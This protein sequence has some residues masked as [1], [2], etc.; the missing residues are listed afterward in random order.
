MDSWHRQVPALGRGSAA[1]RRFHCLGADQPMSLKGPSP[2][3]DLG[4]GPQGV[5]RS[6]SVSDSPSAM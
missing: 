2:V 5:Q 4:G 1:A 6:E 3:A